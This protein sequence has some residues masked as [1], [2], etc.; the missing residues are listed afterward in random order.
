MPLQSD[1]EK[2]AESGSPQAMTRLLLEIWLELKSLTREIGQW[3]EAHVIAG[4]KGGRKKSPG[5]NRGAVGG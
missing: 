4:R 2:L 3:N 5:V 1:L